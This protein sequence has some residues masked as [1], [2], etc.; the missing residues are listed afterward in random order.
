MH[1]SV[2]G[3]PHNAVRARVLQAVHL[4]ELQGE[5]GVPDVPE[6]DHADRTDPPHLHLTARIRPGVGCTARG[7]PHDKHACMRVRT[8]LRRKGAV[9]V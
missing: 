4:H 5:E 9:F 6:E 7:R 1:V 3:A 8:R 2:Q